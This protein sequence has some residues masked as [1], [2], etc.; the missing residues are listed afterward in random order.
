[1]FM[2]DGN[3]DRGSSK[4]WDRVAVMTFLL[5][6]RYYEVDYQYHN[7]RGDGLHF[8]C[9]QQK[10]RASLGSV[11]LTHL[12]SLMFLVKFS[13]VHMIAKMDVSGLIPV[14]LSHAKYLAW[15]YVLSTSQPMCWA[16]EISGAVCESLTMLVLILGT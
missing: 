11:D 12:A 6:G 9:C 16:S 15:T 4:T 3:G 8:H 7:R 5:L 1:M 14:P 13:F 2:W 10:D